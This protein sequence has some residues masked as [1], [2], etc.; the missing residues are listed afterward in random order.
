MSKPNEPIK[1][2]KKPTFSEPLK[3]N[4]DK[5]YTTIEEV[6][7]S[8]TKWTGFDTETQNGQAVLLATER[9]YLA[10]PKNFEECATWLC[11]EGTRYSVFNLD[12]DVR[13]ILKFLSKKRLTELHYDTRTE[14]KGFEL[15]YLPG[16]VFEILT[17]DETIS[18]YDVSQFYPGTLANNAPL[19]GEKK[20]EIPKSWY[21][22]MAWALRRHPEKIIPYSQIDAKIG[23]LL[24]E[25][26]YAGMK[27]LTNC[28][29]PYSPAALARSYF[30]PRLQFNL[31]R[32]TQGIF[33][34]SFRGGRIE[35]YQRGACGSGR[36]YDIKSAYPFALSKAIDPKGCRLVHT[37]KYSKNAAYGAYHIKVN[38]RPDE[39]IP[40]LAYKTKLDGKETICYPSGF[41]E[42]VCDRES[43]GLLADHP[44][45]FKLLDAWEYLIEKKE[46]LFPEI[47][48]LY[49]RRKQEPE[50][51]Q[52]I[53]LILNGLY[54]LLCQNI[55][56][57]VRPD[58]ITP[59]VRKVNAEWRT[60]I[61]RIANTAHYAVAAYTTGFTRRMVWELMQKKPS[62][63]LFCATDGVAVADTFPKVGLGWNLGDW[64]LAAEFSKSIIVGS[65]VYALKTSEGWKNKLRG[66]PIKANLV[67]LLDTKRQTW[68]TPITAVDTLADY[69]R[70]KGAQFNVIRSVKRRLD[71]NFD[72][73]RVWPCDWK[74]ARQLL[75]KKQK[76][77]S[78]IVG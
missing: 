33:I 35:V 28:P 46:L 59:D 61:S 66:I 12:Y 68:E 63:V 11:Q 75:R 34:P 42:T 77:V 26:L 62:D 67:D 19:V 16:K 4:H 39:P 53:K 54:G 18:F 8:P 64:S 43:L 72:L 38:I 70:E 13:A 76:S 48:E 30:G 21:P 15:H 57:Y 60:K 10:W 17:W 27:S 24:M 31:P 37:K 73:K 14:Y 47:D 32:W 36:L 45:D 29:K 22:K 78:F 2:S 51:D 20:I 52:A 50:F 3:S 55:D 25:K 9:S 7:E 65:G 6:L 40:P 5:K 49:R 1:P 74:Y 44:Y 56:I 41:F 69:V 71:I 58:A 23:K